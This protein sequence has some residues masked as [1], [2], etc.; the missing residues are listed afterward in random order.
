ME[1]II[2]CIPNFSEGR[3]EKK[4]NEII[5]EIESAGVE[6]LDREMDSSHNRAVVTFVGEPEAVL[7]A[8]FRGAKK[9]AELIDLT[10]HKG[11]HPRMGA[12]DVIPFVPISN[13][14]TRECVELA[15]RLGKRIADELKIP[16]YLYEAA[17]TRP[18]RQN[19]ANI[20]RGE[21]E[22]IRDEIETNKE[23]RPDFG[24]PKIHPTAGAT[25]VGARFPLIAFNLNLNTADVATA[26]KVAKAIRFM[27][28]GFR[29]CKA[30]GFELKDEGIAQVSIN[31]T[32]YTKTPLYRVFETAKREAERYGVSIRESEI[33]GLVPEQALIDAARYYMQLDRFNENQILEYRLRGKAGKRSILEFLNDLA[34]SKPTPGGGSV[35][36]LEAALGTGLL[37]MV[38]GITWKKTK[39]TE[40]KDFHGHLKLEMYEFYKYV[41]KDK[42][43]FDKVME[44][45]KLPDDSEG[46]K[47]KKEGTIQDALKNAAHVPLEVCKKIMLVYPYAKTLAEKGLKSAISD[48]GV[49]LHALHSGFIGARLNVLINLKSI[50]DDEFNTSTSTTVDSLTNQEEKLFKE[51]E[52]IFL[53][54]F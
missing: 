47:K 40:L 9:A 25:V 28:G 12:T 32:E 29:Y 43:A 10:K 39:D 24:E 45:F 17:A 41:E 4:L 6:L 31:M 34:L 38:T 44:A 23:R 11:E 46:E 20:R 7:E 1:K 54:S 19:L 3:D 21:F 42:Q 53:T 36:A 49:A 22:G 48:V 26:Q 2:E 30:L 50:V 5:T 33:V 15:K 37:A 8:A 51:I 14:T 35:A 18:D 27:S 52:R 13:A 16:I